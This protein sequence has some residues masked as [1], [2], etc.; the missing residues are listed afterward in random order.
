[1][2]LELAFVAAG[3]FDGVVQ[4]GRSAVQDFASG[5]LLIKEAGGNATGIDG[6]D[7]W[8][9]DL[10]VGGSSRTYEDLVA[11]LKDM[12]AVE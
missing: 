3:R 7:P 6:G 10:T 1:M 5:V 9:S 8:R 2:A 12:R 11:A 4:I